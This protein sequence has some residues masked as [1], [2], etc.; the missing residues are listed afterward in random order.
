MSC[1]FKIDIDE[2]DF[3]F[4]NQQIMVV[5]LITVHSYTNN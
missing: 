3:D 5:L 1:Y 4:Q 2:N